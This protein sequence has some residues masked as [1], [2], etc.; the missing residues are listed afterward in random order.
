MAAIHYQLRGRRN[1]CTRLSHHSA[2]HF[3]RDVH[4]GT[5]TII[6]VDEE[7]ERRARE[8]IFRYDDKDFS[9]T[10]AT[11]FAVM[12]RAGISM[13]FTFDRHFAQYGFTVLGAT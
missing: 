2:D 10:N 5:T 11:S 3:L 13:A 7:D 8:I 9:L 1:A 4:R 12:E 6:R